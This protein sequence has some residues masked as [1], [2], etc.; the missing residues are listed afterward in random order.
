MQFA[1]D[2]RENSDCIR[3]LG[4]RVTVEETIE[5]LAMPMQVQDE[6]DLSLFGYFLD[7]GLDAAHLWAIKI[8]LCGIPLP[9]QI[10]A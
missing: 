3:V 7:K 6:S 2:I 10:L 4:T 1:T 8:L 5:F 9:V